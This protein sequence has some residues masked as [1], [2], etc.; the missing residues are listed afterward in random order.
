MLVVY[1]ALFAQVR[2]CDFVWG[3]ADAIRDSAVFTMPL[4]RAL[5]TTEH[6]RMDPSLAELRGIA[7][8]HESYRPLLIASYAVEIALF[9]RA[10]GPMHVDNAIFGLLAIVAA[11]WLAARLLA[12][13]GQAL[14]VTAIFALH[15]LH[16]EPIC[17]L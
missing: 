6:A 5:R 9:G 11:F 7:L 3:D 2:H 1:A 4:S 12:A 8:T 10:P 15:P 16:V 13:T 14:L 17:F